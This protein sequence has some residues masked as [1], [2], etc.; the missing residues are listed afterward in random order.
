MTTPYGESSQVLDGLDIT[1]E[2]LLFY[3]QYH[4]IGKRVRLL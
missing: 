1:Y 4:L 3:K 2:E